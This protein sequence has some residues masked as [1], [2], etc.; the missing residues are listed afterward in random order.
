MLQSL[1]SLH[2]R[3]RFDKIKKEIM[4]FYRKGGWQM[5]TYLNPNEDGFQEQ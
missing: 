4:M 2:N 1:F 5:G 3:Y